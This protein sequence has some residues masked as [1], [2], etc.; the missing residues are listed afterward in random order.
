VKFPGPTFL[1]ATTVPEITPVADAA[2]SP[3][4]NP[5]TFHL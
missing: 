4:G 5:F 1:D 2:L 3:L